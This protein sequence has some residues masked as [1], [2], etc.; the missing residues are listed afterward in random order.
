MNHKVTLIYFFDRLDYE[1]IKYKLTA[2]VASQFGEDHY[3]TLVDQL[4]E[5]E[6]EI[7][8]IIASEEG[9]LDLK[10]DINKY[11]INLFVI[12]LSNDGVNLKRKGRTEEF[13]KLEELSMKKHAEIIF[14]RYLESLDYYNCEDII[15]AISNRFK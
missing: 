15:R 14:P 8:L 13:I 6:N 5:K 3:G 9:L 11:N 10:K 2:K 1:E 12:G 7:S 4:S